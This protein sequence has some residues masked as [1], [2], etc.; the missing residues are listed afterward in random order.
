MKHPSLLG[1]F[2]GRQGDDFD[3]R[4]EPLQGSAGQ[5]ILRDAI[6]GQK[7]QIAHPKEVHVVA[8][9]RQDRDVFPRHTQEGKRPWRRIGKHFDVET[10]P[11]E[12]APELLVQQREKFC[13]IVHYHQMGCDK[14]DHAAGMA[15]EIVFFHRDKDT[16]FH[17]QQA[18]QFGPDC[19][20]RRIGI[21]LED[22]TGQNSF[23]A[24]TDSIATV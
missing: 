24:G 6:A 16:L 17:F 2:S 13:I 8:L 15:K 7:D 5:F 11:L 21:F 14:S 12:N 20:L 10:V 18:R 1:Q 9:G 4:A 22:F 23:S 3:R 19:G